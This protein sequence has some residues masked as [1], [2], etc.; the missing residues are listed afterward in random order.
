[1]SVTAHHLSPHVDGG[2]TG[3][4]H[5]VGSTEHDMSERFR[6]TL[7]AMDAAE[8]RL[9]EAHAAHQRGDWATAYALLA[10][11]RGA[12]PL[13][14]DDLAALSEAAWWLGLIRETLEVSEECHHRL[15]EDGQIERAA[16]V[17]LENSFNWFLRGQPEIGSGW[18]SR[19]RRLLDGLPTCVGHG[20]LLWMEAS[21]QAEAGDVDAAL[22][23]ARRMCAMAEELD[24]PMLTSFGLA[25]EG[26]L[27]IR[28]GDTER[29]FGLLDEAMLPVLAGRLSPDSAGNLYCQMMSICHELADV[30]RA[31]RWTEITES[32]CDGFTSAV[33]FAGI[34]RVH[35]TQLLRL[36]GDWDEAVSA[37][38]LAAEE[39]AELNNEAV[40]EALYEIGETD[41]LR[42]DL[43]GARSRYDAAREFGRDPEPGASLL[44]LAEGRPDQAHAA[45]TRRLTEVNDPFVRARLLRG[46]VDIAL[47]R[48]DL[49]TID[50]AADEL[51]AI[52]DRYRTPGFRAWAESAHGVHLLVTGAV[53]DALAA[54]RSALSSYQVMG[55]TYDAAVTRLLIA[56]ALA[57]SGDAG[58]SQ[59]EADRARA[60]LDELGAVAP[61]GYALESKAR[62]LPGGLTVREAEILVAI[63]E[64]LS[65]REV[66]GHLVISEKTVA[67]HLANVYAKLGVSSRTAAAAWAHRNGLLPTA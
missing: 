19:A 56:R 57:S 7:A 66:A 60:V 63:A 34:C 43:A 5:Q 3:P 53:D 44:L 54:L 51:T 39:L 1:M 28:H 31:R 23:S 55:A 29:G 42:G 13:G 37:A 10:Q 38:T 49:E 14:V 67:R 35:R 20:F 9:G 17:A 24:A 36:Q 21:E 32:W 65:N 16:M 40:G 61:P 48:S 11:L 58:A 41:R 8:E 59:A 6:S 45:I 64:G 62:V 33:M 46:Q 15:L 52:A 22:A 30:P 26:T 4:R 18:I 25:L 12:H 27:V 2:R 50:A 47:V